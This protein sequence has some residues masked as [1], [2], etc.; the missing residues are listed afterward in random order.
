MTAGGTGVDEL[1]FLFS[2]RRRGRKWRARVAVLAVIVAAAIAAGGVLMQA[3]GSDP[4]FRSATV[5]QQ[6][7]ESMLHGVGT[8]QP[9]AQAAVAFPVAGT[10]A[11]VGVQPGATVTAGQTLASLDTTALTA[12]LHQKQAALDQANLTLRNG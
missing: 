4:T 3:S 9:V 2:S 1:E 10:V 6:A 5:S 12:A 11:S 8:I 7:V